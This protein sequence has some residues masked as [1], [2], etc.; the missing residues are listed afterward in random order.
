MKRVN[1]DNV[2]EA[3]RGGGIKLTL[4]RFNDELLRKQITWDGWIRWGSFTTLAAIFVWFIVLNPVLGA[5]SSGLVMILLI[6][7]WLGLNSINAKTGRELAQVSMVLDQDP[8][9]AEGWIALALARKPLLRWVRLMIYHRLAIVRHREQDFAESAAICRGVLEYSLGPAEASRAHL[10]LILT[11]ASLEIRDMGTAYSSLSQLYGMKVS[12][13]EALQRLS[14]Q[15]RYEVMTGNYG[16]AVANI[17]SKLELVE[18][19]P[20]MQCGIV[21]RLLAIGAERYGDRELAERLNKRAWLLC[22]DK[23][24]R[25]IGED[26]ANSKGMTM[27]GG[28]KGLNLGK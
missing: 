17:E 2:K 14:L 22:G 7:G 23:V 8:K 5:G 26:I 6:M 9:R 11:E 15:I 25:G 21:H 18:L 16:A 28:E 27:V 20:A 3:M 19:L 24:I 13:V 10:L 1:E 12:L 4:P